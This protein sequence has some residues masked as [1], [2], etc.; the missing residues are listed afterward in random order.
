MVVGT[1]YEERVEGNVYSDTALDLLTS[2]VKLGSEMIS[3]LVGVRGFR[4]VFEPYAP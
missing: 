2:R 3:K 4:R 1:S